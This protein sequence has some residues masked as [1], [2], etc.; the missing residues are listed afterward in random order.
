MSKKPSF[1]KQISQQKAILYELN[2]VVDGRT[3][4]YI[5]EV[6]SAKH[7]EFKRLLHSGAAMELTDYGTVLYSGWGKH[8]NSQIQAELRDKYNL[9]N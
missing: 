7:N 6:K 8:P 5:L 1:A 9:N 4:W 3:A 2:S